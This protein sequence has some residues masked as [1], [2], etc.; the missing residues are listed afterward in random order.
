MTEDIK[1]LFTEHRIDAERPLRIDAE[2]VAQGGRRRRKRRTVGMVAAAVVA[3][4]A[5]TAGTV[6]LPQYFSGSSDAAVKPDEQPSH[7]LP[8]LEPLE[9]GDV[10]LAGIVADDE[11]K[12]SEAADAYGDAYV[13]WFEKEM[14]V[15]FEQWPGMRVFEEE[16]EIWDDKKNTTVET[17]EFWPPRYRIGTASGGGVG[18]PLSGFSHSFG[19]DEFYDQLSLTVYPRDGFLPDSGEGAQYLQ[20]CED[21]KYNNTTYEQT[22]TEAAGPAGERILRGVTEHVTDD[23]HLPLLERT[24]TVTVFRKDGTAVQVGTMVPGVSMEGSIAKVDPDYEPE[25]DLDELTDLALSMPDA[26]VTG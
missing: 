25:L 12:P 8:D 11:G 19:G 23:P 16:V 21:R 20:N 5:L 6:T 14:S 9:D 13:E 22:C 24:L 1:Q 18:G 4:V 17:D 3:V 2:T 15:E 26:I 7:P 10:Y